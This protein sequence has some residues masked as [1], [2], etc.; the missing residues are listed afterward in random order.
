MQKV[1]GHILLIL[2]LLLAGCSES[3]D[4]YKGPTPVDL[5][6]NVPDPACD[7]AGGRWTLFG[8]LCRDTCESERGGRLEGCS[9]AEAY[10]CDC[11]PDRCWNGNSC[12][13]N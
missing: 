12:E 4:P 5:T 9:D 8:T 2:V 11:G 6:L 3:I 7:M 13:P 10:G 1:T